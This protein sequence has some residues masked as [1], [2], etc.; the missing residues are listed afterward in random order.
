M[1]KILVGVLSAAFVAVFLGG[2]LVGCKQSE[3]VASRIGLQ[4]AVGKYIE[5]QAP[6]ERVEK[7]RK[8]LA[9]V[10]TLDQLAGSDATTVDALRAYIAQRLGDLSPADR[11]AVG[12]LIDLASAALKERVGDGVLK[13][14]D[15][16]KVRD[17]LSW[18]REAAGA[19]VPSAP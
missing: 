4:Y 19:Y 5:K 9:A 15:V 6:A 11:I 10:E 16:L 2:A 17:V 12:N 18:V 8:I 1:K 14:D 13:P 7:A 3:Q